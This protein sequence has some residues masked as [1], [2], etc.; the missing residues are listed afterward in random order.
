M[1]IRFPEKDYDGYI[2]DC[3]GTLADSMPLHYR[4]WCQ[5][6]ESCGAPF[7]FDE[8]RFYS[9]GGVTTA[10]I[11]NILNREFGT[12]LDASI[13]AHEKER[14]FLELLPE[15]KPIPV[16]TEFA[17]RVSTQQPV[18]IVTGGTRKVIEQIVRFIELE[19]LFSIIVTP[20][21]VKNGKPAP[22]MFLLA[23]SRMGVEPAECLVLED[24]L[25]GLEGA[26]NAGMDALFIPSSPVPLDHS[27]S[28]Q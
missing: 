4:A 22:D 28:L 7:T 13:V 26:K 2:F 15:V 21:D 20:A 11:V 5:A 9:M 8:R 27:V 16:V 3:D 17:R 14:C 25:S 18:A 19:D 24:G 6:L 10:H 1:D 12:N 23:A